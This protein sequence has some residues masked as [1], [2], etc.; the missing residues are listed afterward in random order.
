MD[1]RDSRLNQAKK[2]LEDFYNTVKDPN[3]KTL[4]RASIDKI[5]AAWDKDTELIENMKKE[6]KKLREE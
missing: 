2:E 6:I 1:D 3:A 5:F 4:I